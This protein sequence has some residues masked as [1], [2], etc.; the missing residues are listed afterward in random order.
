LRAVIF[1]NGEFNQPESAKALIQQA[2]VVIAADG[3]ARHCLALGITPDAVIGDF[4]SVAG[5]H[6]ESLRVAGTELLRFDA[7][8][9]ETDLELALLHAKKLGAGEVLILAGLGGRWDHTLANLL[10]TGHPDLRDLAIAFQDGPR[11]IY[12]IYSERVIAGLPGDTVSLIP[13]GGDVEGVTTEGLEYPLSDE[14]LYF[15]ATRGVSNVLLGASATVKVGKGLLLCVV[16]GGL[17]NE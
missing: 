2:D 6:L 3:G 13:V 8:K 7:R 17:Q 1:A 15:G 12:P 5:A 16:T 9:D 10:L 14:T 11:R 4:D